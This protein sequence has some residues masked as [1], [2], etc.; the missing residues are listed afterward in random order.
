MKTCT[1]CGT[2]KDE[3][4]FYVEKRSGRLYARC[5]RC[6]CLTMR[7]HATKVQGDPGR[8]SARNERVRL[9]REKR[10]AAGTLRKY[11]TVSY[12]SAWRA[13]HT[14]EA[15]RQ[16]RIYAQ[17]HRNKWYR[18]AWLQILEHYGNKCMACGSTDGVVRDH[19]LPVAIG[20]D[21]HPMNLQPLCQGCNITKRRVGRSHDYR[22]DAGEWTKTLG[23]PPHKQ[24]KAK[25]SLCKLSNI[26]T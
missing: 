3:A 17:L 16:A 8:R 7:V 2:A 19:I 6:Q 21:N 1:K 24:G 22:P 20:G 5:K 9:A 4:E 18:R 23:E 25:S 15:N 10:R 26:Q 11:G 13:R 12:V 14:V